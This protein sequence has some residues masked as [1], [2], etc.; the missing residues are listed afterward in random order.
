[1]A[2][3]ISII[4]AGGSLVDVDSTYL[5]QLGIFLLVF[6]LLRPLLF[7]PVIRLIEA[8]R[9]ATLGMQENAEK[10]DQEAQV[11]NKDVEAKL[12]EVS[13]QASLERAKLVE[14]AR[15]KERELLTKARE[16]SAGVVEQAKQDAA[17]QAD[18]VRESLRQ[19]MAGLVDSVAAKV[20]GRPI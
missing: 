13:S 17:V 19:E 6:L 11:L 10:L 2:I 20:L 5:I 16:D 14:Q 1:M 15:L 9:T 12:A 4:A 7:R 18:Q 8:R 3:P